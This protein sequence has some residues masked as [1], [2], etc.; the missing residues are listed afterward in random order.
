MKQ[1]K[2][3]LE[4]NLFAT[5]EYEEVK[6]FQKYNDEAKKCE[7]IHISLLS[8]DFPS[9][10]TQ[11]ERKII[12]FE[13]IEN[14]PKLKNIKNLHIRHI[15]DENFFNAI[16]QMENIEVLSFRTSNVLNISQIKN[17]KKIISLRLESFTKLENIQ[18][19]ID[20][21][22]LKF[23][24][25]DNCFKINNYELIFKI[26][27]LIGL[28][29]EGN[30]IAPKNLILNSLNGIDN[31]R[32]LKHLSLLHTSIKDKSF[33]EISKLNE[34]LRLDASWKMKKEIREKIK[35]DLPNLTSGIFIAWDFE[36][37]EFYDGI[38]WWKKQ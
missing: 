21:P 6:Y 25:I 7:S 32:N 12:E 27:K 9:G 26:D 33:I 3:Q 17:L 16:C 1:G 23:L 35:S 8:M 19:I 20:L 37:N 5:L 18:P 36:K 28:S 22:N 34:L 24:S 10:T 14:L 4:N 2:H 13:W 31:L 11:N 38:E 30:T 29:I 15:V